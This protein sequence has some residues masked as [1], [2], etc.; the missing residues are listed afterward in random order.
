MSVSCQIC[1]FFDKFVDKMTKL[2]TV[3]VQISKSCQIFQGTLRQCA[4][5]MKLIILLKLFTEV[6]VQDSSHHESLQQSF[7]KEEVIAQ[8]LRKTEKYAEKNVR[9][10]L[11]CNF[12]FFFE[13]IIE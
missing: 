5:S 9:L 3:F 10:S 12:N 13:I 6:K 7:E 8:T 2:Y 1:K 4:M 11:N